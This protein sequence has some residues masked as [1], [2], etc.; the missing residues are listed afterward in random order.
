M[1][2]KIGLAKLARGF[3]LMSERIVRLLREG[4]K[5]AA[6]VSL[7]GAARRN[8]A[9]ALCRMMG[10]GKV[11]LLEGPAGCGKSCIVKQVRP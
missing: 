5:I 11:V 2:R 10:G 3:F 7:T 1:K 4:Q 6:S 9:S 8:V